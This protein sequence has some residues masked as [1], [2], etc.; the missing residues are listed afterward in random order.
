MKL[1]KNLSGKSGVT[2][3]AVADD[4]IL[5]EF[6]RGVVYLYTD[7]TVGANNRHKMQHL[8]EAGQGLCTFIT[9]HV[10]SDYAKKLA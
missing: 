7:D 3:Y 9:Q 4:A 8:A 1:Y 5:V 10:R 2:A 6:K